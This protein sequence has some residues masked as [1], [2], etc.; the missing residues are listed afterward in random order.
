MD[1]ERTIYV[2][3]SDEAGYGPNLGPLLVGVSCWKAELDESL[4]GAERWFVPTEPDADAIRALPAKKTKRTAKKSASPAGPTL[5]DLAENNVKQDDAKQEN[6]Q[7]DAARIDAVP[8]TDADLTVRAIDRLNQGLASI[9]D[10]KGLFPLLDSKKLYSGKSLAALERSFLLALGLIDQ[11]ALDEPTFGA[12]LSNAARGSIADAPPWEQNADLTLPRDPKTG[13]LNAL[14]ESLE[15]IEAI[16][17]QARLELFE[18]RARR[19]QP[20][21]FNALVERLGLKSDLIADVTTSLVAETIADALRKDDIQYGAPSN[22]PQIVAALCDK[23]GGR[24]RYVPILTARFPNAR[25]KIVEESRSVGVYRLIAD[26]ALDRN[27]SVIIFPR[28]IALEIRFTAKGEVNAPTALASICAKYLR[29]LSMELFNEYWLRQLGPALKP[30]AGYP[31][32]ALRFRKDVEAKRREL[33][34][35]DEIFWRKK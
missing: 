18:L 20:C 22:A 3:G 16:C 28:K 26:R 23:L 13:T 30:T 35:E 31:V 7:N 1:R 29:E 34:I 14:K 12:I 2:I 33:G 17:E 19:V 15:K 10:R 21:E 4:V 8:K 11:Q 32:D 27:G 6:A 9:S 5:F 24:D 25:I